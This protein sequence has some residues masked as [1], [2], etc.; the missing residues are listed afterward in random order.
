M[1]ITIKDV[2]ELIKALTWPVLAL[3]IFVFLRRE[4]RAL[5]QSIIKRATK[6]SG[7]GISVELAANQ[8]KSEKILEATDAEEKSKALRNLEIAT[9]LAP[10]FDYWM[11]NFKHP[12]GR[13]QYDALLAWLV[14]DRGAQYISN[15]YEIF[16]T[17]AEV[18]AKMGYGT[19]PAPSEDEFKEAIKDNS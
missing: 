2:I 13:T 17:L 3:I 7:G 14:E 9:T 8:V 10:K 15:N 12:A 4:I 18:L 1:E 6:L 5:F 19:I 11:K 16:K